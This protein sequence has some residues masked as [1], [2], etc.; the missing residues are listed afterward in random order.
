[1]D[2]G[3]LPLDVTRPA[4]AFPPEIVHLIL[5]AGFTNRHSRYVLDGQFTHLETLCK[6]C[7]YRSLA[8][9]SFLWETIAKSV[10]LEN[11]VVGTAEGMEALIQSLTEEPEL[12]WTIRSVDASLRG[13]EAMEYPHSHAIPIHEVT[14]AGNVER[15]VRLP[16]IRSSLLPAIVSS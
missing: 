15:C 16:L 10:F 14:R 12:E 7:S 3:T 11:V 4:S 2:V 8:K 1:M 5:R 9:V 6:L 13:K